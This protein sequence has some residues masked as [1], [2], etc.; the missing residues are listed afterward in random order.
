MVTPKYHFVVSYNITVM[1]LL[2]IHYAADP[3]Q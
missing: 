2:C 1:E 3:F